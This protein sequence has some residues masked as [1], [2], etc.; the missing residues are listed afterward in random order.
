MMYTAFFATEY[1]VQQF[2]LDGPWSYCRQAQSF[3]LLLCLCR[4]ES[5]AAKPK[6][7][8]ANS[9][10]KHAEDSACSLAMSDDNAANSP[11]EPVLDAVDANHANCEAFAGNPSE[12]EQDLSPGPREQASTRTPSGPAGSVKTPAMAPTAAH[13]SSTPHTPRASHR[14][15]P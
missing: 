8:A 3:S 9:P 4:P 6:Q 10:A 11:V 12:P 2:W 14:A 7:D 5:G 1:D 15:P 13:A